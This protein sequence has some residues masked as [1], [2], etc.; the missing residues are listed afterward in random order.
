MDAAIAR[1]VAEDDD[2]E[3]FEQLEKELEDDFE[4]AGI[5]ERRMEEMKRECVQPALLWLIG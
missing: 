3:L 1:R 4:L 5:R 2:D